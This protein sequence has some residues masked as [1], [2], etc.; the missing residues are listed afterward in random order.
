M[1]SHI[2]ELGFSLWTLESYQG[3]NLFTRHHFF[4][5][6]IHVW[7][8]YLHECFFFLWY[9]YVNIPYMDDPMGNERNPKCTWKKHASQCTRD[10][11]PLKKQVI[12]LE[13]ETTGGTT[14]QCFF[15]TFLRSI[16]II[17]IRIGHGAYSFARL[18]DP[19]LWQCVVTSKIHFFPWNR[20]ESSTN[21]VEQ[22]C[23]SPKIVPLHV[24]DVCQ[25][26]Q[27]RGIPTSRC[28]A[29]QKEHPFDP[30][31]L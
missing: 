31:E 23:V 18:A 8:I 1:C 7:Y 11:H 3:P 29:K 13:T 28:Q 10:Q 24:Y 2:E 21:S 17:N 9:M 15:A 4:T 20:C 22:M 6:R 27:V 25:F 5:H 30:D 26:C 19:R 14:S 16:P 12:S